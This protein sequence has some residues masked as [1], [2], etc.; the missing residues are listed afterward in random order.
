M[1]NQADDIN[2]TYLSQNYEEGRP[3][4]ATLANFMA[5]TKSVQA[6]A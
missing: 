2:I 5:L 6:M 4:K 3:L 1:V